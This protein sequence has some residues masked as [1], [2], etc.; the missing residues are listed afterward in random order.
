MTGQRDGSGALFRNDKGDNQNR[1]DYR[2]DVT[3]A[4]TKYRLSGWIK[5]TRDGAKY[6]SL[7]AT[8][9]TAPPG[10]A[11]RVATALDDA[12]PW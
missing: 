1:P 4:G 8:L 9:D 2:G 10:T 5:T 12:V 6:L 3:I 7:A 11:E